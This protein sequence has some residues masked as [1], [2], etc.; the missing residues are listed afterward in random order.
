[1]TGYGGKQSNSPTNRGPNPQP[2]R[3]GGPRGSN[4][5]Q[6][7]SHAVSFQPTPQDLL[8]RIITDPNATEEMVKEAERVGSATARTLSTSQIRAIFGE[9]RS[10]EADWQHNPHR[11]HHRLILLKPKMDYRAKK[12]SGR[13]VEDLVKVLKPAVD[14][15]QGNT[16]N[17]Q[18]F[19]E[20]FEAILAYH[21]AYGGR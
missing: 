12:E 2:P 9:V 6:G 19:V 1:M 15:V 14:L 17:F 11:A 4:D 3:S 18:R 13:G 20:F 5:P 10:I 7:E 16:E 21:R 8:K